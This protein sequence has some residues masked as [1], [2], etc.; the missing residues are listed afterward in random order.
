MRPDLLV[1]TFPINCRRAFIFCPLTLCMADVVAT[2]EPY[3]PG[4]K[5]LSDKTKQ[6]SR[7]SDLQ[8]R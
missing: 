4:R 3:F 7:Q 8:I 1:I 6:A 5:A 2:T